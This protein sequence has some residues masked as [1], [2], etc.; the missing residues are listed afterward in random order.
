M[1]TNGFSYHIGQGCPPCLPC[2]KNGESGPNKDLNPGGHQSMC[3]KPCST[4][5]T[6]LED[7]ISEMMV[8]RFYASFSEASL[9]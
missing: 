4:T 6:P 2:V 1:Y 7:I 9:A 8:V 5:I 3:L